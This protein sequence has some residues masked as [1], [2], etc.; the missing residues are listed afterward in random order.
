M[1]A[2]YTKIKLKEKDMNKLR[3]ALI[4]VALLAIAL[5]SHGRRT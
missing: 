5:I 2:L 1:I 3:T 4:I